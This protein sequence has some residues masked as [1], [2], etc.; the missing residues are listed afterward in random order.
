MRRLFI[1]LFCVLQFS[2]IMSQSNIRL[3]NYW[4]NMHA[5]TPAW[6]YD[7]YLAVFN[8][9]VKKQWVGI[10]GAPTTLFASGSTYLEDY[11]TQLGFS[12]IQDKVGYT[13]FTNF[14]LSYAYALQL[15][16]DWELHMGIGGNYQLI[17]FDISKV[18]TVDG[19]ADPVL[20]EKLRNTSQF[21]ADLG[22]ELSSQNVKLGFAS[23][24]VV[25][26]FTTQSRIQTNTNF[27]YGRYREYNDDIVNWGVGACGIQYANIYQAEF[28]V[29]TYFKSKWNYGLTDK[30]DLFD[31]G[32]F[33]RTGSQAGLV[34][35][36]NVGDNMHV[37][38]SYDYHFGSLSRGSYGTNEIM[39]TF[40]LQRQPQCHNC[41]Y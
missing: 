40:N 10:E 1:I 6:M 16:Y 34:L 24:N 30:P 28:N 21:D 41:W 4:G 39:L 3:N 33:Y 17:S 25:D 37:S 36:F 35:G 19:N 26:V 7:E 15:N 32:L 22:L 9:A 13:S 14:N 23:Q 2:A 38:Y 29:T 27:L 18:V 31:V 20:N 5:I 8:M 11:H 12:L